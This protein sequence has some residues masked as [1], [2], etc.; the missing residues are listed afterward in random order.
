MKQ[1][2]NVTV[3]EPATRETWRLDVVAEPRFVEEVS[4]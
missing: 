1:L 4:P 2:W 3:Y